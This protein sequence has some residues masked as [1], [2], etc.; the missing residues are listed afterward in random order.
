MFYA[1]EDSLDIFFVKSTTFARGLQVL[2]SK[3]ANY[4]RLIH[5]AHP[6]QI[7]WFYVHDSI[8]GVILHA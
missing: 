7:H 6:P 5:D 2:D 4:D 8:E 1:E 3:E